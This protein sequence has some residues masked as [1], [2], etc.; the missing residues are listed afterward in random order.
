MYLQAFFSAKFPG[1]ASPLR[2]HCL[3][4]IVA[5]YS[6]ALPLTCGQVR[7][8][9]PRALGKQPCSANAPALCRLRTLA[10]FHAPCPAYREFVESVVCLDRRR[11]N[12]D[13]DDVV[14]SRRG[15]KGEVKVEGEVVFG[16]GPNRKEPTTDQHSLHS[17]SL[18]EDITRF[19]QGKECQSPSKRSSKKC[20]R[21]RL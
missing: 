3:L 14:G 9:P 16:F 15:R 10:A 20:H 12:L 21:R 7:L 4:R 11:P 17:T 5:S 8:T 13:G 2:T 1:A 18:V 19:V 6:L